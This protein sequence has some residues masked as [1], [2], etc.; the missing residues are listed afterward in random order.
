MRDVVIVPCYERPEYSRVCLEYLSRARGIENKEVWL[1]QDQH[2]GNVEAMPEMQP[3]AHFGRLAF[4]RFDYQW[5]LAHNT[6]GNSKNLLDALKRAYDAGAER[7]FLVEDDIMVAPDF[8]EWHEAVLEEVKPLVSC[9]TSLNRSAHF[10]INGPNA[11]D[12]S[13]KN[14]NAYKKV[15]GPYSSHAAAFNKKDLGELL[16]VINQQLEWG[17]WRSGKEQD[18][19]IQHIMG[20]ISFPNGGSV[21]PY[22]PRAWNVGLHS[23]HIN[24]GMKFNGILEEKCDALR[25][26]IT[27]PVKLQSMSGGNKAITPVPTEFAERTGPLVRR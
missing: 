24:T 8:F 12:E 4:P 18:I 11:M 22:V 14:P 10:Q 26:A 7:I 13:I 15:W 20:M 23:Y 3:V 21:W 2:M 17:E 25:R 16:V 1:C 5:I 6:Y 19:L 9:A 27:D